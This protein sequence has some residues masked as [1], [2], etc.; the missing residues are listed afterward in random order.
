MANFNLYRTMERIK[1][2]PNNTNLFSLASQTWNTDFFLQGLTAKPEKPT[3]KVVRLIDES[4]GSMARFKDVFTTHA[5][6]LV[7]SGWV[8]LVRTKD[9]SPVLKI[10]CTFNTGSP[11]TQSLLPPTFN[12]LKARSP[13]SPV[14]TSAS[15]LFSSFSFGPSPSP[16]AAPPHHT[17]SNSIMAGARPAADEAAI[18]TKLPESTEHT[19]VLGLSVWE[20]AYL[21]DYGIDRRAY[22]GEFW[23]AVDWNRAAVLME[24]C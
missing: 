20:H 8:W 13:A 1:N 16:S 19:P 4:F 6:S 3:D 17:F 23:G 9:A 2:E 5:D 11:F 10:A 7:G 14:A 18:A 12:V 21:L 24:A 22:V 15:G